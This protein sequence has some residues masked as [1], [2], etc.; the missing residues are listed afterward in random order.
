MTSPA[1]VNGASNTG[2]VNLSTYDTGGGVNYVAGNNDQTINATPSTYTSINLSGTADDK[3]HLAAG[4]GIV[5][6]GEGASQV[7]A[8]SGNDSFIFTASTGITTLSDGT[9]DQLIYFAGAGDASG[10]VASKDFIHLDGFTTGSTLDF[11]SNVG[12]AAT[13][14]YEVVASDGVTV[15]GAFV[16]SMTLDTDGT[17][18]QLSSATDYSFS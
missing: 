18:H 6:F 17:Y 2:T 15:E 10:S 4:T 11:V 12:S 13:Q 14:L 9:L 5:T 8:G 16:V 7:A 1:Y 3:V